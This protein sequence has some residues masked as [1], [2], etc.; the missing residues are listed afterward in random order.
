M[1]EGKSLAFYQPPGA[2]ALARVDA[3]DLSPAS[4]VA[5]TGA[6]NAIE[7]GGNGILRLR[8]NVTAASGTIPSL[9]VSVDTRYDASDSWRTVGSFAAKT[10]VS[11]ERKV[12][13]GIDRQARISYVVSG[14]TPSFTFTCTGEAV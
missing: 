12:F 8:L 6:G 10:A 13:A 2:A 7:M 5:V 11:A 3:V 9:T 4:A 1:P 14:T